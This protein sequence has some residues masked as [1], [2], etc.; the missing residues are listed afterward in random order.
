MDVK[1]DKY[2]TRIAIM[3]LVFILLYGVLVFRLWDEQV[4]SSKKYTGEI[5][6]QSIRTI[7]KPAIRGRIYTS[8]MHILAENL[9]SYNLV[10]YITEM[11]QRG[12][13]DNTI[14]YIRETLRELST[15]MNLEISISANS[16]NNHMNRRPAVAMDILKNMTQEQLGKAVEALPLF[17]GVGVE[18]GFNRSYPAHS[19]AAHIL[20]YV[21][22]MDPQDDT[23]SKR[24][25]YYVPSFKGI[26][27]VE[28]TYNSIIPNSRNEDEKDSHYVKG[29]S[30]YPG[31]KIVRVNH[32]GYEEER[33]DDIPAVNGNNI[34]LNLDW[35]AQKIT[36]NILEK[37]IKEQR[38]S[39]LENYENKRELRIKTN[40]D[41]SDSEK[42]QK[43][44]I[45]K[46]NTKEIRR[47][48]KLSMKE[49]IAELAK[50]SA[51][52]SAEELEG[53]KR[54][55]KKTFAGAFVVLNAN[56]GAVLTMASYPSYD[57]ENFV[58]RISGDDYRSLLY[59]PGKPLINRA[60]IGEYTPGSIIKPIVSLALLQNNLNPK[61]IIDCDGRTIIGRSKIDCW[62]RAL[63]GGSG[64]V[65]LFH[66]I[67]QS[68]NKY[69]IEQS[70]KI[71]PDPIFSAIY[72]AGVGQPT[73]ID[74]YE[75]TGSPPS[76]A[77]KLEIFGTRW[78]KFDTGLTAIGQGVTTV[79]PLRV[80]VYTAAIANGGKLLKP[81][82][83]KHVTDFN[84]NILFKTKPEIK[85]FLTKNQK[86][87]EIIRYGMW[88]V[89][90]GDDGSSKKAKNDLIELYGK[91][92]TAEVGSLTVNKNTW[93]IAFGTHKKT[94][95]AVCALMVNGKSGGSSCAPMVKEFFEQWLKKEK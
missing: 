72:S 23:D 78:T 30:G 31:M 54:F 32:I 49:Q 55:M 28:K 2:I 66:A 95:Y 13:R 92:G 27:G 93:F 22:K 89:V 16:I 80:A 33:L 84:G 21:R 68:C 63:T 40:S 51:C 60:T 26:G 7:R 39:E 53:V 70:L 36:E 62:N 94:T 56:T 43:Y 1:E 34:V 45:I 35:K 67:A 91:S 17:K 73:G 57:L 47:L 24:F 6:K 69:F 81:Q 3:G 12:A 50:P 25:F 76:Y 61:E 59:D 42:R 15:Y 41:L 20:K 37:H 11:R 90:N 71:G 86:H 87:L 64:K 10:I 75:K 65:N 29:L 79:T 88:L 9:P 46:E 8:D 38:L 18:L 5:S 19:T 14:K 58:P 85:G 77:K 4:K 83:L 82:L 74:I 52:C 44:K 48:L